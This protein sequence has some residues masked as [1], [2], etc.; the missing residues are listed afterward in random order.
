MAA[1]IRADTGSDGGGGARL[2]RPFGRVGAG[3][4]RRLKS[5]SFNRIF[6]NM[7]TLLAACAGLTAIRYGIAG[8]WDRSIIAL[9]AAGTLDGVDGRIARLLLGTSKFGAELDSPADAINFGVAPA[10]IMYL[11]AMHH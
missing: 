7:L 2:R 8:Q 1:P 3:A 10:L 6:P 9:A 5:L 4:A 11:W